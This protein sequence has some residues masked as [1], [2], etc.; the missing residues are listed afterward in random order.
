MTGDPVS[1]DATG[2]RKWELVG[3][4]A[5]TL[6]VLDVLSKWIVRRTLL[7]GHPVDVLGDVFRLT[8]IRNPGAAFG[9]S[10]GEHSRLVFLL[11]AVAALGVLW[12][13]ARSTPAG[14]RFRLAAVGLVAG[15]AA[16]NLLDRVR[17]PDGVVDFLD[18]GIGGVRWPVF[19]LADV[20]VTLGALLLAFSLWREE[21][22]AESGRTGRP[23]ER[24]PG[25]AEGAMGGEGSLAERSGSL[26]PP[27]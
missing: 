16:G 8:Y 13:I 11:L 19:N 22:A 24:R 7:L 20:G 9:L 17:S 26:P 6:L 25:S 12:A 5:G 21:R 14:D 2:G 27:A 3:G 1:G 15:G 4:V 23:G 18:V 10:A